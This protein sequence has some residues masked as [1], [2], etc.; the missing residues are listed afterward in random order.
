MSFSVQPERNEKFYR[1]TDVDPSKLEAAEDDSVKDQIG[2]EIGEIEASNTRLGS[3][4]RRIRDLGI[5]IEERGI[6]P[7]P[8]DQRTDTSSAGFYDG[9]SIWASANLTPATFAIGT[10]G[11]LSGMGFWDSFAVIVIVDALT[12]FLVAWVGHLGA[13]TGMRVMTI[14]RYSMGIW[15]GRL[16]I[17]LQVLGQIGWSAVNSLSGAQVLTEL[18]NGKCHLWVGNL[19][20][21]VCAAFICVVGFRA[22]RIFERWSWALALFSFIFLAGYGTKYFDA[23][24]APMPKGKVEAQNVLSFIGSCYSFLIPWACYA[25]DYYVRLPKNTNK[26]KL[27]AAIWFGI[28]FGAGV[29]QILGAAFMTA[30]RKYPE[31]AQAYDEREIGGIMGQ[32]LIPLHGFGKFLL[33]LLALSVIA[34]NLVNL[35]SLAFMCQNFHPSFVKVPRFVWS[36]IGAAAAMAISIGG[37]NNFQTV[38]ESV[39]SIIGYYGTSFVLCMALEHYI[40]RKRHYPIEIWNDMDKLPLGFAGVFSVVMGFAGA[41]LT[42]HQKW[43][44]GP[45]AK[46]IHPTNPEL[47]WL[48]SAIFSFCTFIPLRWLEIKYFRR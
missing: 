33:V 46:A 20:I 15:G 38:L 26:Y 28:F 30:V 4:G 21:G 3:L 19:I 32:A 45:I 36:F 39:L 23:G 12:A 48:F 2:G 1:Y 11:P 43:F 25:A 42:M 29:T 5:D 24:V 44:T 16:V 27:G 10:L 7:V 14:G 31:F 40:F 17:I 34:C 35:Y 8:V 6:E 13:Q 47:G 9:F 41:I 18:S 22:V 37:E